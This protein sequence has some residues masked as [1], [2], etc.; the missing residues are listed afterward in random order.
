M[1]E[2]SAQQRSQLLASPFVA[3]WAH[4]A[5]AWPLDAADPD[6][7]AAAWASWALRSL[8]QVTASRR[9]YVALL[10]DGQVYRHSG[11]QQAAHLEVPSRVWDVHDPLFPDRL[12]ACGR[13]LRFPSLLFPEVAALR[14]VVFT[15]PT[16]HTALQLEQDL[17]RLRDG[18]AELTVRVAPHLG[19][20]NL[21][22]DPAPLSALL[23]APATTAELA[24]LAPRCKDWQVEIDPGLR[25]ACG[26]QLSRRLLVWTIGC[27]DGTLPAA[28]PR[29][30]RASSER[31]PL[32]DPASA[33]PAETLVRLLLLGRVAGLLQIDADGA[34]PVPS[35]PPGVLRVLSARTGQQ[36]AQASAE[37]AVGFVAQHRDPAEAW[38]RLQNLAY[39]NYTL[40][41]AEPTFVASHRALQRCVD[42]AETPQRKDIN[43]VLPLLA[44][45][46]G[47]VARVTFARR[48]SP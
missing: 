25:A 26:Q 32:F 3:S 13:A 4:R 16:S 27:S 20:L 19:R 11:P 39:P 2:L 47:E 30:T 24:A 36:T 34:V 18:L 14:R 12:A 28:T 45:A 1:T 38:A 37:A 40:L 33:A 48:P 29:L 23:A 7:A 22:L 6:R 43:T 9:E 17:P 35:A 41:V 44:T 46:E 21:S 10:L 42:R 5:R 31:D 15:L 8:R